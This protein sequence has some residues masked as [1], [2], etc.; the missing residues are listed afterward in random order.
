MVIPAPQFGRRQLSASANV[1]VRERKSTVLSVFAI[2][3][4]TVIGT[5]FKI[6]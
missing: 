2:I 6:G 1:C 4:L 5:L 3:I